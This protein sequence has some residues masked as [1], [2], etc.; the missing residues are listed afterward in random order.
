M[1]QIKS[2]NLE[3]LDDFL[4]AFKELLMTS[5][6]Y[7]STPLV[8]F[9]INKDFSRKAF[10][11]KIKGKEWQGLLAYYK[12]EL[13]GFLIADKLYG[14]VSYIDWLG[15]RKEHRGMGVGGL[16][17]KEWGERVKKEGGHK[18][19]LLTENSGNR[20]F[21]LKNGFKEEGLEEK[22]WFGFDCWKFG[23]VISRP[24]PEKFLK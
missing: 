11:K 20:P 24:K 6:P 13:I 9:F 17:L 1:V 7:Y 5:F 8:N 22:S 16:L 15:V 18:L 12:E 21:Y 23:K 10:I 14:G 3:K 19:M 4:K 2:L